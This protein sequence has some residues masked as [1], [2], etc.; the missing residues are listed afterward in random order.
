MTFI[1]EGGTIP[2]PPADTYDYSF[3]G[4]NGKG[5]GNQAATL[6]IRKH[7]Q[8]TPC[9]DCGGSFNW[10][11]MEVEHTDGSTAREREAESRALQNR[12]DTGSPPGA[13]TAAATRNKRDLIEGRAEV[14]CANCHRERTHE[15]SRV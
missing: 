13:G 1:P 4:T 2:A 5:G 3:F 9:A 6:W 12:I 10:W 11:I 8:F 14:V 15:R 7:K